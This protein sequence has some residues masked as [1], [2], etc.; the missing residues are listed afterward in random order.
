MCFSW[1]SDM[2]IRTI[3][4]SSSN[5]NSASARASSVLP[6]PVGPEEQEAADR[7][8]RIL[9]AGTRAAHRRGDRGDR[10]HP[11]RPRAGAA[12]PPSWSRRSTSPSSIFS[13]GMPVH[14]ATTA[15]MSSSVTSS[16]R[17]LPFA[18]S[19]ST[20]VVA[21]ASSLL[22]LRDRA[23]AQL[24]R[25]REVALALQPLGLGLELLELLLLVAQAL[26]QL[27]LVL[28][29]RLHARGLLLE[30]GDLALDL[31]QALPCDAL[32][33]FS[34]SSAAVSTSSV[35]TRRSRLSIGVG[36]LSIS[37]L[38]RDAASSTRSIALSGS[39]RDGM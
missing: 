21:S 34:R 27:A 3:A 39:W 10:R 32:V 38:R 13:T 19:S 14:F 37:I 5:R 15:A 17:K 35:I 26:D 25:A 8:V 18:R 36:T 1:Y 24:R 33:A 6:T 11:G 4:D 2:S 22:E 29:L 30:L 31:G 9:E 23:E 28:P 12:G 7:P 20:L 16:R